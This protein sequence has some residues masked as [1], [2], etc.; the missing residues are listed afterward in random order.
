MD[1]VKNLNP[2]FASVM[3]FI[4]SKKHVLNGQEPLQSPKPRMIL[5]HSDME[6]FI[7]QNCHT[8]T[9]CIIFN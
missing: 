8:C 7:F 2:K 6:L 5:V 4:K 3:F 9:R 1:L